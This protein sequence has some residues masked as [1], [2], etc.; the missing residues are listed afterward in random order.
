M[1]MCTFQLSPC[2][3]LL[4]LQINSV[5]RT[6]TD[7][8]TDGKRTR[9]LGHETSSKNCRMDCTFLFD[10]WSFFSSCGDRKENRTFSKI[11]IPRLTLLNA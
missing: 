5:P 2:I 8:E 6:F 7:R 10:A 3:L 4:G 1:C 11:K 9:T